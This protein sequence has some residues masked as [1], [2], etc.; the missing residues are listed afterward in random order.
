MKVGYARFIPLWIRKTTVL[1]TSPPSMSLGEITRLKLICQIEV[2]DWYSSL[3]ASRDRFRSQQILI[4]GFV[5]IIPDSSHL[6]VNVC[7]R[8][9]S[10][11]IDKNSFVSFGL[12]FILEICG[13]YRSALVYKYRWTTIASKQNTTRTFNY[14]QATVHGKWLLFRQFLLPCSLCY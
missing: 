11:G 2:F 7:C 4:K 3:S 10:A 1:P 12:G 9:K 6:A 14:Q 13:K 8:I 5:S